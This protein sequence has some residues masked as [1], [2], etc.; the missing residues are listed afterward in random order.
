M[1]E[2]VIEDATSEIVI[3]DAMSEIVIEDAMIE[4]AAVIL[5]IP[6]AND[7]TETERFPTR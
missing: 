1:S 3:E 6:T 7:E 4:I 5:A 2:I